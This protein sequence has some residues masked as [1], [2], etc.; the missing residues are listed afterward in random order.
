MLRIQKIYLEENPRG[1]RCK[2]RK[3]NFIFTLVF[4]RCFNIFYLYWIVLTESPKTLCTDARSWRYSIVQAQNLM[5]KFCLLE[6]SFLNSTGMLVTFSL[7]VRVAKIENSTKVELVVTVTWASTKWSRIASI[8]I[9]SGRLFRSI[10]GLGIK[11]I[12]LFLSKTCTI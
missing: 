7:P 4:G 6:R 11:L 9:N 1:V 12:D 10:Y 5:R 2:I 3:E 8:T